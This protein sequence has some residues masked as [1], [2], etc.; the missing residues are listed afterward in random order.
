MTRFGVADRELVVLAGAQPTVAVPT[1]VF[2]PATLEGMVGSGMS[3][4][5]VLVHA[6][7]RMTPPEP[8]FEGQSSLL[9]VC[10]GNPSEIVVEGAIF[11]HHHHD[12]I[13][14]R[15]LRSPRWV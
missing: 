10:A 9:A 8:I 3:A 15:D 14:A 12:V 5:L 11:H 4:T 7:C 13:D 1:V 6:V 2:D